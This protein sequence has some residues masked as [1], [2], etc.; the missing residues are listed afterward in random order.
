[1]MAYFIPFCV[2]MA[3]LAVCILNC[4]TVMP[5]CLY[6]VHVCMYVMP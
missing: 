2:I 3:Q 1:M 4:L 5:G 6:N